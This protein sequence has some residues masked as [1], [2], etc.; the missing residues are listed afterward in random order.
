[1][2]SESLSVQSRS[3]G[4]ER[5]TETGLDYFGARYYN[6]SIGR[7]L[8]PD[9]ADEP[10]S[11]PYAEFGDPQS[12]NLYGYVRNSPSARIDLDGHSDLWQKLRNKLHGDGWKTDAQVN[13][14]TPPPAS[15]PPPKPPGQPTHAVQTGTP[16]NL[17]TG[18]KIFTY[19][20]TDQNGQPL[21]CITL[22]EQNVVN[23]QKSSK[24]HPRLATS[25]G[26]Y[27]YF[28]DGK[29]QDR[30]G[31]TF[32]VP[33]STSFTLV[34]TQTFNVLTGSGPHKLSTTVE[35]KT[36]VQ[37]GVVQVTATPVVP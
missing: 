36:S 20:V 18:A 23:A 37:S 7:W 25:N 14:G 22:T 4:K 24:K 21:C 11:V 5:D 33:P 29:F 27:G 10:T 34:T 35:Q 13:A 17:V 1:M 28:R 26:Q 12:L 30:V 6:N 2:C 32:I 3:S 8:S 9:W 16:Q 15:A 31:P 19:Q